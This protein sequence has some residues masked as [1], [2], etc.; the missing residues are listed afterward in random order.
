[1]QG[2]RAGRVKARGRGRTPRG[3]RWSRGQA[4]G[5]PRHAARHAARAVACWAPTPSRRRTFDTESI[6]SRGGG[7]PAAMRGAAAAAAARGAGAAPPRRHGRRGCRA[8]GRAPRRERPRCGR[9]RRCGAGWCARTPRCA[10]ASPLLSSCARQPWPAGAGCGTSRYSARAS[11]ACDRGFVRAGPQIT[12]QRRAGRV[13]GGWVAP[14]ETSRPRP[15]AGMSCGRRRRSRGRRAW[16]PA[17]PLP[18]RLRAP[19]RRPG[20]TA[21]PAPAPRPHDHACR[22]RR[23]VAR[24]GGGDAMCRTRACARGGRVRA[25]P[26]C[27]VCMRGQRGGGSWEAIGA[28]FK[29]GSFRGSCRAVRWPSSL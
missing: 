12:A 29:R 3:A 18:R 24:R 21:D 6:A 26:P 2:G 11:P 15:N 4:G 22:H 23:H 1:V 25:A 7:A 16:R 13:V 20:P 9:R 10:A 5:A 19:A 14:V 8:Q 17:A 28:R 27:T